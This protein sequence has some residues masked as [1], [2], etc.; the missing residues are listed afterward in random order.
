MPTGHFLFSFSGGKTGVSPR[1]VDRDGPGAASRPVLEE[2]VPQQVK[3]R[4]KKA[5]R[6]AML[7]RRG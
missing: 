6:T 5:T 4:V 3:A 1:V 7:D 2:I